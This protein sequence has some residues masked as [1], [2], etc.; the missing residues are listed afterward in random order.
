MDK[1]E[2]GRKKVMT[3]IQ[4]FKGNKYEYSLFC[5]IECFGWSIIQHS[6]IRDVDL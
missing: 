5:D 4:K 6:N 1:R 2:R 3:T